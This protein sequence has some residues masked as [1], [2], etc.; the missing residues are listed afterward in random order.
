MKSEVAAVR[1]EA[2]RLRRDPLMKGCNLGRLLVCLKYVLRA[3]WLAFLTR[4]AGLRV[5]APEFLKRRFFESPH[6]STDNETWS[7]ISC[8]RAFD[9]SLDSLDWCSLAE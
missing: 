5:I 1:E 4:N 6:R 2:K 8:Y 7:F 9:W 3:R